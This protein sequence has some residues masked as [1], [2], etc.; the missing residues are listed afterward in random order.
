MYHFLINGYQ[1]SLIPDPRYL[2]MYHF[3]INGYQESLIPDPRWMLNYKIYI[4][5]NDLIVNNNI[6]FIIYNHE[7]AKELNSKI[8]SASSSFKNYFIYLRNVLK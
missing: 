2:K 6:Y 5:I 1:E 3:L 7:G 8:I 4:I